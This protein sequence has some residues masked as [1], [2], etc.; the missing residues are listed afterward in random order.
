MF[1]K[2]LLKNLTFWVLLAILAGIILGHY[3]PATAVA[4]QPLGKYFIDIVKLF[5]NP[6][7]VV[8]IITGICGMDSMKTVGKIGGKALLYF[9]IVTT[10]AL[11]IGIAVAYLVQPG[12]GID[13]SGVNLADVSKYQNS[14]GVSMM[15]FFRENTTIQFLLGSILLGVLISRSSYKPVVLSNLQRVSHYLFKALTFV[16]MLS[17]IGAFG[18]MAFT[19]GKYGLAALLPL[20]KLMLCVYITMFLFIIF[21][22]GAVLKYYKISI[23]KFLRYLRSE[24]LIVLGTSSSEAALP[25]LMNKLEKM[26]CHRSVVGL[27]VPTGYSFNLDGTS[28]YLSM[29]IVFLAQVFNVQ[30]TWEQIITIIGVLMVTSKGAAGVTGSGFI[31]LASTLAA[32]KVIP[33]QGLALLLGVDRFM[34]EARAITNFIG[35]GVATVFLS[36]HESLFDRSMME[37][38]FE[39]RFP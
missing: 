18:G 28:I 13:A 16:M 1:L 4:M 22:L 33:V 12:A 37:E 11:V 34:S 5:I 39:E 19:I 29:A 14:D 24:L 6:I 23:W 30:L 35:N 25:A 17:P 9:E 27:V 21:V 32:V 10:L 3:S 36:N 31:I 2:K 38:R 15:S 26:G 8:T 20:G 7:I